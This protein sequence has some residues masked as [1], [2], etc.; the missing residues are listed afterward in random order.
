[1]RVLR[2]VAI[3]IGFP[4]SFSDSLPRGSSLWGSKFP[5]DSSVIAYTPAESRTSKTAVLKESIQ[6]HSALAVQI[7]KTQSGS[8]TGAVNP[9][10]QSMPRATRSTHVCE[11]AMLDYSPNP[12][13]KTPKG[14]DPQAD[15]A[16]WQSHGPRHRSPF[17]HP[18]TKNLPLGF[19]FAGNTW[20]EGGRGC[21]NLVLSDNLRG[22][23]TTFAF[24][25]RLRIWKVRPDTITIFIR[26]TGPYVQVTSIHASPRA[27]PR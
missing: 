16:D 21:S 18:F 8:I 6:S 11:I 1:M 15:G 24:W 23:G 4:R 20:S 5:S 7:A 13:S 26:K 27:V 22:I 25:A 14:Q 2:A 17:H 3:T 12:L 10:V 9:W 19:E